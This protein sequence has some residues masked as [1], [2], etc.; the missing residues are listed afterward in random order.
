MMSFIHAGGLTV[1]VD[2]SG[3]HDAPP[4]VFVNSLGTNLHIWDAQAAALAD[5]FRIV[6]Y[7]MRGHGMTSFAPPGEDYAIATLADDLAALLDALRIER[8]S[9]VGISIGGMVAQRFAAA[10]PRRVDALVLCATGSRIGSPDVWNARIEAI[11]TRGMSAIVE[12]VVGRW[13]TPATH[14]DRP[15]LVRGFSMMLKRTPV[16]GYAGCCAGIRDADLRADDTRIT[17][18]TFVISGAADLVTPPASGAEIREAIPG[19]RFEV[20]DDAA[21]MLCAERPEALDRLLG[22]FIGAT[23]SAGSMQ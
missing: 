2:V 21:H 7:D 16:A 20:I 12:G 22:G 10:Y 13:F 5:R 11:T 23:A 3:P 15:D 17:A 8:A 14:A 9:V 18:R 4:I 1:H 19:A 6:R